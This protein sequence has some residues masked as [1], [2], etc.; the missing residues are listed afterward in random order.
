[1]FISA[2]KG[3]N[4]YFALTGLKNKAIVFFLLPSTLRWAKIERPSGAEMFYLLV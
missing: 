2:L 4:I 3:R 1:L